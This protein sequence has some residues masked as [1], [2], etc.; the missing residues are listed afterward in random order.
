MRVQVRRCETMVERDLRF[1]WRDDTPARFTGV[2]LLYGGSAAG[3][4]LNCLSRTCA[5]HATYTPQYVC[6]IIVCEVWLRPFKKYVIES[7][8][9]TSG[10]YL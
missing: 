6:N 2:T 9:T 8:V 1:P 7:N 4:G 5:S 10:L 3:S